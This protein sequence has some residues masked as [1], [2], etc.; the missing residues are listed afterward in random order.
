MTNM[1]KILADIAGNKGFFLD[2]VDENVREQ[3]KAAYDN[4]L[5]CV[6]KCQ[7]DDNG[8][9]A[10]WC[11]QHDPNDFLPT[12]G[13][14]HELPS[15]SGSESATLLSYLMTIEDP[16]KELQE[17]ITNAVEWLDKHRIEGWSKGP[18]HRFEKYGP[19]RSW[20]RNE[21]CGGFIKVPDDSELPF[22]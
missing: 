2:M 21:S 1:M 10:A 7:V 13:R 16:S 8:T 9:K 22:Q 17:C 18:Q 5:Q 11:A 15:I 12:E 4:A 19:Q 20:K 3:C 6:I 14:P